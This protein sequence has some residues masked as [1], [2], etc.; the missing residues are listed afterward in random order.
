MKSIFS[1][2]YCRFNADKS[3]FLKLNRARI[4][5]LAFPSVLALIAD[6]A[7]FKNYENMPK[8]LFYYGYTLGSGHFAAN[9]FGSSRYFTAV[10]ACLSVATPAHIGQKITGVIVSLTDL[11]AETS[12]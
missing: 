6:N 4:R 12:L 10:V 3:G 8:A 11:S 9:I 2:G 1:L 7:A 5:T